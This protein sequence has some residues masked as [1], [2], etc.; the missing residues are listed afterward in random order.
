MTS[1]SFYPALE[2]LASGNQNNH[3]HPHLF[4]HGNGVSPSRRDDISPYIAG[5]ASVNY[6]LSPHKDKAPQD[7]AKTSVYELRNAKWPDHMHDV[8]AAI[9]H[10]QAKYTF[11]DKYLLVGHSVGATMAVLSALAAH[12]APF[13][14]TPGVEQLAKIE[15]PTAVLGVSGIYDFTLLHESFPDYIGLTRNA[16]PDETDD[17]LASPARYTAKE[18]SESWTAATGE[19]DRKRRALI[20]AHSRDDGLVDW[21]Q[22]DAMHAVFGE[23]KQTTPDIS[24]KFVEIRGAHADIFEKGTELARAIAEAVSVMRTLGE[25]QST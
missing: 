22:V 21:R 16:I 13:S 9:A 14:R 23:G 2:L 5:Y 17:T 11:G 8:L 3:H 15:P 19:R 10:L 20:I 7:Q 24:V 25:S 18:F 1:S 4:K 6:R 12:A